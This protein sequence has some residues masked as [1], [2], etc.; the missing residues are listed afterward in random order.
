MPP[1]SPS[2]SPSTVD[3]ETSLSKPVARSPAA[4]GHALAA[5]GWR[6]K[7]AACGDMAGGSSASEAAPDEPGRRT[8]LQGGLIPA[9][10]RKNGGENKMPSSLAPHGEAMASELRRLQLIISWFSDGGSPRKS[11]G[12]ADLRPELLRATIASERSISGGSARAAGSRCDAA[13]DMNRGSDSLASFCP[14]IAPP[15]PGR[16][17]NRGRRKGQGTGRISFRA[18]AGAFPRTVRNGKKNSQRS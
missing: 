6:R 5:A 4:G 9:S 16:L 7:S 13:V 11:S 8:S 10:K 1:S 18:L 14:P 12:L 2:A 15:A 3:G 17:L